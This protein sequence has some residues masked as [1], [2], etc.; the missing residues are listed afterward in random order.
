[1]YEI[2]LFNEKPLNRDT[3][4]HI[5][6]DEF[7]IAD[8]LIF[9]EYPAGQSI[10]YCIEKAQEQ[11]LA[12][13]QDREN[14]ILFAEQILKHQYPDLFREYDSDCPNRIL[15]IY[16]IRFEYQTNDVIYTIGENYHWDSEW[17]MP[18]FPE[19]WFIDI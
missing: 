8:I 18:D 6:T 4:G 3:D 10:Q 15:A 2:N 1:M 13:W 9:V 5:W 19:D 16:S 11:I 17:Q 7:Q 12:V 14:A